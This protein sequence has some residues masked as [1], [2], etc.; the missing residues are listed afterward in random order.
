MAISALLADPNKLLYLGIAFW[1]F[2]AIVVV[3]AI[4][5]Y[6][7][8]NRERQKTTR[9]AIEK[10]MQL[11]PALIESL[12]QGEP[13]KPEDYSIGGYVSVGAGIGLIIF[14]FFIGH[15]TPEAL[16]PLIGAGI[17][18]ILVGIS[19]LYVAKMIRRKN[20]NRGSGN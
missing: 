15:T 13:A 7:A 6:K 18:V 19:L 12:T 3:A 16:Y 1:V 11:D 4:W 8:R 10:G 2:V 14:A 20:E 9:L 17:L 5:Y